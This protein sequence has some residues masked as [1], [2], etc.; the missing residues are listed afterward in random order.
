MQQNSV[1][2]SSFTVLSLKLLLVVFT[3][4]D[5]NVVNY[6]ARLSS[7]EEIIKGITCGNFSVA[8]GMQIRSFQ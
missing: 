3:N 2:W 1:G 6:N 5:L 7:E 4:N 8:S